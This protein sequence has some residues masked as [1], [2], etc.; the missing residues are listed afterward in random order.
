MYISEL[1]EHVIIQGKAVAQE[2]VHEEGH[3]D[4]EVGHLVVDGQVRLHIDSRQELWMGAQ[5]LI[6][7][8]GSGRLV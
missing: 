8:I 4:E 7:K 2:V 6:H 1:K 3:Y 5:G